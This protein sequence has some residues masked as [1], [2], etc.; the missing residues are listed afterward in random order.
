MPYFLWTNIKV[1]IKW[2]GNVIILL[3]SGNCCYHNIFPNIVMLISYRH[4]ALVFS[5]ASD[6]LSFFSSSLTAI[7][8]MDCS[9]VDLE[10]LQALYE[11]VSPHPMTGRDG[12]PL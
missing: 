6:R 2:F 11:N 9:V 8:N 7:L 10:T 3:L 1:P 5:S 12:V 4:A